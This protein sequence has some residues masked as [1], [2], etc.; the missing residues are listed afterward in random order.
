MALHTLSIALLALALSSGLAAAQVPPPDTTKPDQ[1]AK[2]EPTSKTTGATQQGAFVNGALNVPGAPTEGD[3]IP[4]K[5]SAQNAADDAL[6]TAAYTFKPLSDE[7]KLAIYAALKASGANPQQDAGRSYDV[8]A[9]LPADVP[10]AAVPEEVAA[11]HPA[12]RD[13]RYVMSGDKIL[14]V[15]AANRIVAGVLS[16]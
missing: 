8:S 9:Q 15:S 13:Y 10:V 12:T 11:K 4:A 7:E 14:L 16:P 5:F 3:T 2:Q 6:P 1:N